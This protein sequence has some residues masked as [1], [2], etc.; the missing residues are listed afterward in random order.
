MATRLEGK[1]NVEEGKLLQTFLNAQNRSKRL[2]V[3]GYIGPQSVA[4]I[5][6]TFVNKN[7]QPITDCGIDAIAKKL[8]ERTS[9]KIRA[10]AEVESSGSAWSSNG[11]LKLLYER[12]YFWRETQGRAGKNWFSNPTGGDYT[13]DTN[14]NGINDSWEK[15]A[16]ASSIDALAAF[17]SVSMTQFQIMGA[18]HAALGYHRPWEMMLLATDSEVAQYEMMA[19][20]ILLEKRG[21]DALKEMD[22][23]PESCR[24]FAAFWNGSG[25]ARNNYHV[26]LANAFAK[27]SKRYGV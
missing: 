10:V 17:K 20:W 19:N 2:I 9:S 3:D 27:H 24:A 26:K 1:I 5:Y 23:D 6:Q 7:A 15:L 16:M 12:H 13:L 18:H 21:R 11:M 22:G 25:Y 4:S 14:G 8:G